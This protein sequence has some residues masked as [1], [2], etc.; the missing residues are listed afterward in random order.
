MADRYIL[1]FAIA[2]LD[3]AGTREYEKR[4]EGYVAY[5]R[6]QS[7][8]EAR[9]AW[10]FASADWHYDSSDPRSP[11]YATLRDLRIVEE[12]TGDATVLHVYAR[13]LSYSGRRLFTMKY[14]DVRRYD[15]NNENSNRV[16][17]GQGRTTHGQLLL[18]EFEFL[19]DGTVVHH[20]RWNNEALWAVCCSD[21]TVL[22]SP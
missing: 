6:S 10:A 1:P 19:L 21:L 2:D 22:W 11:K 14:S 4:F 17:I 12:D 18:D 3:H 15:L 9:G 8:H 5:L 16:S 7:S 13:L 20:I